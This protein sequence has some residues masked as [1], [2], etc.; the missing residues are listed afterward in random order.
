MNV[1]EKSL[2]EIKFHPSEDV[3]DKEGKQSYRWYEESFSVW[4]EDHTHYNIHS[5]AYRS[6]SNV[7]L[8]V[9]I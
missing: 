2:K 4:T 3:N 6:R 5:A 8:Q 7:N 9:I 1:K